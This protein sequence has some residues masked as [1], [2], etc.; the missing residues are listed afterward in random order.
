MLKAPFLFL[1][2]IF[3]IFSQVYADSYWQGVGRDLPHTK[4]G[5]SVAVSCH[6]CY[7]KNLVDTRGELN[8]ALNRDFDIIEL[9]LSLQRDG[10]I[11]V[12]HDPS[13]DASRP[14]LSDVLQSP[15]LRYSDRLLFLEI[16]EEF[17]PATSRSL[18]LD[19]LTQI[20]DFGL[21]RQGRTVALR[22]FMRNDAQS[23]HQNLT[24]AAEL[25]AQDEF[26]AIRPFIRLHGFG[27][28]NNDVFRAKSLGFHAIEFPFESPGLYEWIRS[29]RSQDLGVGV[30]TIPAKYGEAF[31]A[32]Y[33][34]DVDFIT[35]D[36]DRE[37]Q[38]KAMSVRDI[39]MDDNALLYLNSAAQTN[40]PLQY[41]RNNDQIFTLESMATT[42]ALTDGKLVFQGQQALTSYDADNAFDG[43][44]LVSAIVCFDSLNLVPGIPQSI[45]AKSDDGGFALELFKETAASTPIVRFGVR[46]GLSYHYATMSTAGWNLNESFQL[47]GAYDGDGSARLWVNGREGKATAV[48]LGG[49]VQNNSPVVIGA[50]P[51]GEVAR[52][53]F[54]KGRVQLVNIQRW[55]NHF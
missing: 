5:H 22:A 28:S 27:A 2:V 54:F 26:F 10:R 50:D 37:N 14:L 16:K 52:R 42:P 29:A 9:D 32:Q 35:T 13:D 30:W 33:R 20:R 6:N 17:S 44:F 8:K 31:L 51:Q 3:P 23:P 1:S 48:L 19:L 38:A 34:D 36:Y 7:A 39:V 49:V 18:M 43:G 46:V 55:S 11:H 53:Y 45:V 21:A 12:E 15:E 25:L 24:V 41:T 4:R 47:L 40:F